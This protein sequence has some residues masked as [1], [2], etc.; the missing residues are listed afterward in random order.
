MILSSIVAFV[1]VLSP[2]VFFHEL[3]HYLAARFYGAHVESFSI[4]FGPQLFGWKDKSGTVWKISAIPVGGYV[5]MLADG[6]AASSFDREAF[7]KLSD[8]E[9]QKS[10]HSKSPLQKMM[11][12]FAGPLA[13]YILAFVLFAG[14]YSYYGEQEILPIVATAVEKSAAG[15]AG[16]ISGDKIVSIQ[17]KKIHSFMDVMQTL[18]DISIKDDLLI[19]VERNGEKIDLKAHYD[20]QKKDKKWV[21]NLGIAPDVKNGFSTKKYTFIKAMERSCQ[22]LWFLTV[23]PL[24]ILKNRQIEHL[25]GPLGIAQQAG[26]VFQY[27]LSAILLFMAT[28]SAGLGFCNLLP[29][30]IVDGGAIVLYFIEFITGR[31][32]PDK[33]HEFIS[34]AG[35]IL[36]GALFLFITWNDINRM[37]FFQNK[38]ASVIKIIK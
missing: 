27:G 4:G 24:K 22:N 34:T 9:K 16:I 19:S 28:V 12:F 13:N 33:V 20:D 11:I 21:G 31:T 7:D 26:H 2:L 17:G 8:E 18:S 3:G 29:I 1:L 30:P 10:M 32:I 36:L 6:D 35:V 37:P 23:Q 14:V 25:G 38:K 15:N 5:K